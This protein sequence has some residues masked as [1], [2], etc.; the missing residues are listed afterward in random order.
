MHQC[1]NKDSYCDIRGWFSVRMSAK[2]TAC[3]QVRFTITG[4]RNGFGANGF[5]SQ[6]CHEFMKLGLHGLIEYVA[7]SHSWKRWNYHNTGENQHVSY[8][9]LFFFQQSM[10]SCRSHRDFSRGLSGLEWSFAVLL[11]VNVSAKLVFLGTN[12]YNLI[13]VYPNFTSVHT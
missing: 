8:H 11:Q 6:S 7:H 13:H 9:T 12:V 3:W 5:H 1:P 10:I 4:M 2:I